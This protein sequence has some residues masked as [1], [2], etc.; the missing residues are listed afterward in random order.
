MNSVTK[1]MKVQAGFCSHGPE[2]FRESESGLLSG[3]TLG[4][5]DLFAVKGYKNAAGN[6]DW[7]ESHEPAEST[8]T[9]LAILLQEGVEFSGFTYTD[10]LAYSLEGNN[11]HFGKSMNP[12]LPGH[13]C[14][15]SSMG[16]AAATAI[17]WV[18]I[19]LGTDT[20][21]SIRIPA[22]YCGLFGIRPSHGAVS[23]EGLIGLAPRFDTAGWFTRN[24][25]LLRQ[26]G[27]VLL[28][29]SPAQESK[30]LFVDHSLLN[31]VEPY[32][33][34]SLEKALMRLERSFTK[35]QH[36]D[37]GFDREFS[38]LADCFRILQGRAIADYHQSWLNTAKPML[39]A[40]VQAR[41][42]MA[43]SITDEE[44]AEA[45]ALQQAFKARLDDGLP[46]DGVFFLPTAPTT[47][48][49]LGEDTAALR[50]RLMQLTAIAGLT[51]SAQ[52]HLPLMPQTRGNKAS[53]PYGFSLLQRSG[54][55]RNLLNTVES[56][57]TDWNQEDVQ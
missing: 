4:V 29:E 40:P 57:V 53:L 28:P 48:P 50:P 44:F 39:S 33:R 2:P 22:C 47:A 51:G 24:P 9:A 26:V 32:L 13:A 10:E 20:G 56:V 5:K 42:E 46:A 49:K 37:F 23:A 38:G 54:Q 25:E 19:G 36:V 7:Y 30:A 11:H 8:A 1:K 52:V 43:L 15:G 6:P 12:K 18:D 31:L 16:S 14:G 35:M 27:Q 17:Q 34:A 55:D 41:M 3:L 21:G 45:T